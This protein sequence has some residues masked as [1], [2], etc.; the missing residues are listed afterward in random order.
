MDVRKLAEDLIGRGKAR[1]EAAL[2]RLEALA[3][4]LRAR[5]AAKPEPASPA[6]A[7]ES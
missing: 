4:Q 1:I 7:P 3:A 5:L 6:P 2:L